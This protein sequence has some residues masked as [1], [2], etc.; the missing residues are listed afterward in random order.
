MT[1]PRH[2]SWF[3]AL[4]LFWGLS[5]GL[6]KYL[7]VIN[8][9]VTHT[10]FWTG[11]GVGLIMLVWSITRNGRQAI[12]R[13]VV[14]YG[15]TCAF[16]LN[17]PFGL[18]LFLAAYVPPTELAIVHTISPFLNYILALFT[19]AELATKRR[20]WAIVFGFVSTLVLII[21]RE[22]A[23]SGQISGW[24]LASFAIPVLYMTYN[25]YGAH[26]A[27]KSAD[28][29]QLGAMESLFSALWVLP[30]ML[31]F[32]MPGQPA[33]PA[34]WQYGILPA[35]TVMWVI[36]RLAYF[37]LIRE[38]GAVYTGQASYVS[39]PVAVIISAVLFGG[40]NDYWLWLSLALLMV[41]LWLN[42]TGRTK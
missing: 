10:I 17:I 24:L 38:K 14:I 5:P 19:G 21:S 18:T 34:L 1:S 36:E 8:M 13:D 6:Y 27:P 33:Q 32:E 28:N 39:T 23:L 42:N 2:F 29:L 26:G 41:A 35:V 11:L 40:L 31:Y 3:M 25:A 9:P 15:A 7:S 37:T 20:L 4:G 12:P 30:F 16:L 22:G